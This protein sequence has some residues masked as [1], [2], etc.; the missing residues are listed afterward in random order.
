[1]ALPTTLEIYQE[2]QKNVKQTNAVRVRILKGMEDG[3]PPEELLMYACY[4]LACCTGDKLIYEKAKEY[5]ERRKY[6]NK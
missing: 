5:A 1:M 6:E 3:T 4:G 2:Y